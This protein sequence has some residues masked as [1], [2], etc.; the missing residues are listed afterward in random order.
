MLREDAQERARIRNMAQRH[1]PI[2]HVWRAVNSGG[3]LWRVVLM[4]ERTD[5]EVS[6]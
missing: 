1:R 6:R 4:D 3:G 2:D 5:K